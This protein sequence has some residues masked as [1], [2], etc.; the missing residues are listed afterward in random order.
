MARRR[1]GITQA[2]V[3]QKDNEKLGPVPEPDLKSLIVS[4]DVTGDTLVWRQG[5][6]EWQSIKDTELSGMLDQNGQ[7]TAAATEEVSR[8]PPP[9]EEK[10]LP[11]RG[12]I[13]PLKLRSG[14]A[15]I[16][17]GSFIVF[18]GI[19]G[20]GVFV[21]CFSPIETLGADSM[22]I[23]FGAWGLAALAYLSSFFLA[24]VA[25]CFFFHRA[26]HNIWAI[27]SP[28]SDMSAGGVWAWHFVPI[29]NL[30][31][32]LD[33]AMEIW[34]G[35][36]KAVGR[37][38]AIPSMFAIWW[39]GWLFGTIGN[40]L[41][42]ILAEDAYESAYTLTDYKAIG[43]PFLMEG[44]FV[45]LLVVSAISLLRIVRALSNAQKDLDMALA[46]QAFS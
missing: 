41:A 40:N 26:M 11:P 7:P 29:A 25:Y 2:W 18:G 44:A 38:E 17:L 45:M 1:A 15:Q 10:I 43:A 14:A 27:R 16:A 31:K 37:P 39:V 23:V 32:P 42:G 30:F 34:R 46:A 6:A 20:L 35:T 4:G 13:K 8:R 19:Y 9:R 22:N 28:H 24:V 21:I 5:F 36:M 3:Y 12:Q 33:G